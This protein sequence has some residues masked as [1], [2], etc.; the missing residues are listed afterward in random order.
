MGSGQYLHYQ[1]TREEGTS[2][3]H[4]MEKLGRG[5]IV[6]VTRPDLRIETLPTFTYGATMSMASSR[7][8][9]NLMD[10]VTYDKVIWFIR[11]RRHLLLQSAEIHPPCK[12]SSH[13]SLP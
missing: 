1:C 4:H 9:H 11:H 5:R 6:T 12:L 7:I 8:K 13:A 3:P 10:I 2:T